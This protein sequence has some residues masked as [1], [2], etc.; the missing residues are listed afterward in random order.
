MNT[1]SGDRCLA[2]EEIL[3]CAARPAG[4]PRR[5][6]VE[7]CPRCWAR[8]VAF[9]EFEAAVA[10]PPEAKLEQ[11]RASIGA[12]LAREIGAPADASRVVEFPRGA[13]RRGN[14]PKWWASAAALIAVAALALALSRGPLSGEKPAVL[15]GEVASGSM[16][17]AGLTL[18]EPVR[19]EAGAITL[20]WHAVPG[21][22]HYRVTF[23]GADLAEIAALEPTSDTTFT[24]RRGALP[25][26]LASGATVRYEVAALASGSALATSG[27]GTV[28][29]P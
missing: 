1:E 19:T 18:L 28:R 3:Q 17:A 6:H 9:R 2:I 23:L 21:A 25:A 13:R 20:R 5:R 22:E 16:G 14:G 7:E 29:L 4:D 11:A 24:L 15:R 27:V 26:A 8:L 12:A 10:A